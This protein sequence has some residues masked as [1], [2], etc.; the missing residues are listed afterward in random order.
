M[1]RICAVLSTH[2]RAK[3]ALLKR[4]YILPLCSNSH[5][6]SSPPAKVS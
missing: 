6:N 4:M 2:A 3:P 5:W 1:S